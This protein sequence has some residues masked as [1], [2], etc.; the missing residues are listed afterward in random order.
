MTVSPS[1][2]AVITGAGGDVGRAC[3]LRLSSAGFRIAA[4]GRT[5]ATLAATVSAVEDAGGKAAAFTADVTDESAVSAAFGQIGD[6]DVLVNNAGASGSAPLHKESLA[7]LRHMIDVNLTGAFLCTRA[8]LGSMRARGQGRI[9]SIASVAGVS[10]GRYISSY[11]AAKHA[12]VGLMRSLSAE[13][14]GTGITANAVC[15]TYIRSEMTERTL[16]AMAERSG[17]SRA[18]ALAQLVRP[19]PLGRLL[20]PDEVA[21]AVAFLVSE[22]AG[23]IN[24]QCLVIDG[25]ETA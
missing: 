5:P 11:T 2:V 7:S 6:V 4:V 17:T 19:L 14:A 24:G 25:G 3:A 22:P 18:E 10:G 12:V 1:R 13:V 15:P 9:V 8:A 20:E 21:A 16:A 23:A